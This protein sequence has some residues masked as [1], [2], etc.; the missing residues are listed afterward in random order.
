MQ[1]FAFSSDRMAVQMLMLVGG[2]Y[3]LRHIWLCSLRHQL[4]C[5]LTPLF[6]LMHQE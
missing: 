2:C 4:P 1:G 6:A 3:S 5:T